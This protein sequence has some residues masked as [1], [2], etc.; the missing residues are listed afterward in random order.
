MPSLYGRVEAVANLLY[1]SSNVQPANQASNHSIWTE[2]FLHC[3]LWKDSTLIRFSL[4]S[5]IQCT[6]NS[7]WELNL[8]MSEDSSK[9]GQIIWISLI[10]LWHRVRWNFLLPSFWSTLL[11]L[12]RAQIQFPALLQISSI[13]LV[14]KP[15]SLKCSAVVQTVRPNDCGAS[16]DQSALQSLYLEKDQVHLKKWWRCDEIIIV[17]IWSK[18]WDSR[19]KSGSK[20]SAYRWVSKIF[21][22][23]NVPLCISVNFAYMPP[24][25]CNIWQVSCWHPAPSGSAGGW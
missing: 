25:A 4:S 3:S 22:A 16:L 18:I 10:S 2:A 12:S 24:R 6:F 7:F 1:R 5:F 9:I 14:V 17:S 8:P 11:L 13:S 15:W 19:N 21:D 23:K 20:V